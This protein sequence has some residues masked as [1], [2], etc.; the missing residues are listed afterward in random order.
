MLR[1]LLLLPPDSL[2][3]CSQRMDTQQSLIAAKL[4]GASTILHL[5]CSWYKRAAGTSHLLL[6]LL[7][8]LA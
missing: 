2:M 8:L 1:L 6:W 4:L 5:Y 7:L 3:A